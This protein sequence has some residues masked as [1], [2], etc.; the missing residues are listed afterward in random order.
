MWNFDY[1]WGGAGATTTFYYSYWDRG[2]EL[3]LYYE[4]TSKAVVLS[5]R[6]EPEYEETGGDVFRNEKRKNA[7]GVDVTAPFDARGIMLMSYRYKS[8]DGPRS[9]AKNDDTWV[10]VPTLRRVRRIST[11]QR[12][13][14]ISG[15]DF[16]F[17][18]LGSFAGIVP[19]YEWECL[20]EMDMIGPM[21][22]K[23][24]AFPY[25]RDHNFGPY[26]LSFADDRWE[27]RR[28]YKVRMTPKN[29]DHPYHHKDIYFDKETYGALYSFAYDQKEEL[30]KI[31]WH[32][33]RWSED[34]LTEDYYAGWEGVPEPRDNRI[35]SDIIVNV[36]TGTGNR[37]E[38]WDN[39]GTPF[40]SK[41]KIRRY[42]D[43]G[44]L[45]KG[46]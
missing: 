45:T 33:K 18:D 46:R 36:Q 30:W 32:N 35:I 15:T 9:E 20:G 2:E 23:V 28:V 19:Q 43:V 3:P 29:A 31:I 26:G 44:R 27:M 4:G 39:E 41:G 38:I 42:I 1:R 40:P 22:T 17:D 7:F 24:K 16:T 21:N 8:T 5:H 37:I 14:S 25:D 10:Y 34:D 6:V 13:D 11:A 12:T